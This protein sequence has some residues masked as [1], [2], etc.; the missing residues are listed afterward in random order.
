MRESTDQKKLRILTRFTQ[1]S[2]FHIISDNPR[3]SVLKRKSNIS[4]GSALNR[5]HPNP[6]RRDK[7]KLN[8]YFHTSLWCLKREA[9][10]R[11]VKIKIQLNFL[12][13]CNFQKCTRRE[14]LKKMSF[15]HHMRLNPG[16][17][18][19]ELNYLKI[20]HKER[21]GNMLGKEQVLKLRV[22]LV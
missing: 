13:Q 10:Q 8:F 16:I 14:G 3:F 4:S 6:R 11:S 9:P 7:I 2:F 20:N 17:C 18:I 5:S 15:C 12:F 1:W 22:Q 19:T 21:T